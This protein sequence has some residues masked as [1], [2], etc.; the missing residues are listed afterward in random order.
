MT[1]GRPGKRLQSIPS[2]KYLSEERLSRKA[3]SGAS[4]NRDRLVKSP[5]DE[6]SMASDSTNSSISTKG[7]KIPGKSYY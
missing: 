5:S 2:Q 6:I 4:G 7:S 3:R 1:T